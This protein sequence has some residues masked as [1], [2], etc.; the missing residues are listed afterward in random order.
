MQKY[1]QNLPILITKTR[2]IRLIE[3]LNHLGIL[4]IRGKE[5]FYIVQ[6]P[7]PKILFLTNHVSAMNTIVE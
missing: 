3:L 4:S 5:E 7:V 1:I 2:L 6:Y